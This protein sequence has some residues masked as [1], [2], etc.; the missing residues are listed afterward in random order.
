MESGELKYWVAMARVK[1]VGAA[2]MRVLERRFGSI[3]A[4]WGASEEAL[5]GA[6][7]G[8]QATRSLLLNRNQ[9]DPDGELEALHRFGCSA[10]TWNDSDYPARL[11]E[12]D[13]APP[14]LFVKGELKPEDERSIAVVGT[15][16]VS[17]YGRRATYRFS[18][19]F[20]RA[21]VVI[22]SG[23]AAGVD[24]VAH[25]AALEAG[26]R[27]IAV[28]ANGLDEIYPRENR[29]LAARIAENG[30]LVTEYPLGV[31]PKP[32][33][34]PRR[35]RILSGIS[36]GALVVEGDIKSGALITARHAI[37]QNR[38][39][40]AV[41][42]D[43]FARGS[44]GVNALIQRGE[45]KLVMRAEDALEE[46]NLPYVGKQADL[47]AAGAEAPSGEAPAPSQGAVEI[48]ARFPVSEDES[49]ILYQLGRE[50]RHVDEV[51]RAS[52]MANSVV[53]G[54]LAMMELRGVVR[55]GGGMHY[56][57]V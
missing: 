29:R 17:D 42:G 46:L 6:G 8:E 44:R 28:L 30:A 38:E 47:A 57:R 52:K 37:D 53:S 51:I 33:R 11:K 9:V 20:A 24:T 54:L 26:R 56:V 45:A 32:K 50:P 13:D 14:T 49:K 31:R 5:R 12:V 40:F 4:A 36:L 27:T 22:V 41:P 3:A 2:R 23:L 34:F 43:V 48:E 25:H 7:L 35:N 16:R 18:T 39:V 21:N 19:D 55:Q 15:R 1:H 10:I